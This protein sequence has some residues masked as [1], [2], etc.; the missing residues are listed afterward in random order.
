MLDGI[1]PY[2]RPVSDITKPVNVTVHLFLISII[3]L[4]ERERAMSSLIW[5]DLHWFDDQLGWNTSKYDGI[6]SSRVSL[7]H[8]WHPDILFRNE[9]GNKRGMK[10][11]DFVD[12]TVY[13]TGEVVWWPGKEVRTKCEIDTTKYPFDEQ[14][15]ILAIGKWYSD[16][17]K[18]HIIP[19]SPKPDI[20]YYEESEQ[21]HLLDTYV[22]IDTRLESHLEFSRIFYIIK[23]KRR[24]TFFIMN[25]IMPVLC[26]SFLNQL[27]FVLPLDSG[28]KTGMCMAIFLTFAVFLSLIGNS[29]PQSSINMPAYCVYLVFQTI[30]SILTIS[31]EVFIL[32]LYNNL[33][34]H[35]SSFSRI[36][37]FLAPGLRIPL[38]N[39]IT[40]TDDDN[41]DWHKSKQFT[42]AIC[43]N[44]AIKL[45]SIFGWVLF[46]CNLAFTLTFF[47]FVNT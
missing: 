41:A 16:D 3:G 30:L 12:P 43:Q 10:D 38:S 24:S 5:L 8:I 39:E 37:F 47:V 6:N 1:N 2:V 4:Y 40:K 35:D 18:I 19:V 27:C 25:V 31:L 21:W 7:N 23:V 22:K 46:A 29:L 36:A 45:D 13:S 34:W 14:E 42:E 44:V 26:L 28:E 11:T 32:R 33:H 17:S 9:I 20:T 15:C